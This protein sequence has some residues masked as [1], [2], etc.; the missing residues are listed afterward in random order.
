VVT[1]PIG[2]GGAEF[3]DVAQTVA[4]ADTLDAFLKDMRKRYPDA[5]PD[6][7]ERQAEKAS[8]PKP[9]PAPSMPAKPV[10][11]NAAPE[12]AAANMPAKPAAAPV[13]HARPTGSIE[14]N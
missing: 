10:S 8:A 13:P 4:G 5:V 9:A 14:R 7:P 6:A 11:K 12:K 1:A 3:K 2:T